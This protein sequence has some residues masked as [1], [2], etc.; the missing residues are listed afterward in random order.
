MV[1]V[2]ENFEKLT[3]EENG[4]EVVV[5][6]VSDFIYRFEFSNKHSIEVG[7][8]TK[9]EHLGLVYTAPLYEKEWREGTLL[10]QIDAFLEQRLQDE[11]TIELNYVINYYEDLAF[12]KPLKPAKEMIDHDAMTSFLRNV[13]L[14]QEYMQTNDQNGIKE[15][16]EEEKNR[17]VKGLF[18]KI[19]AKNGRVI[20][21]YI[22]TSCMDNTTLDYMGY[23]KGIGCYR[24]LGVD[25]AYVRNPEIIHLMD[26]DTI[27]SSKKT[28]SELIT[29]Y[30]EN[31]DVP[32]YLAKL[33]YQIQN[34]K[35]VRSA[36][37]DYIRRTD[38]YNISSTAGSPQISFRPAVAED[39]HAIIRISGMGL[40]DLPKEIRG[41]SYYED[42][43]TGRHL[44]IIGLNTS[45]NEF[46]EVAPVTGY[47]TMDRLTGFVDGS[48][49]SGYSLQ[50][51]F[52]D[53][54]K[55]VNEMMQLATKL[56][57]ID[58][59]RLQQEFDRVYVQVEKQTKIRARFI[60][61]QAK[62]FFNALDTG[63]I[64]LED[65]EL[66]VEQAAKV[67]KALLNYI[68]TNKEGLASLTKEDLE[69]AK[70]LLGLLNSRPS[71]D[72]TPLQ[73]G[74][75]EW[76]GEV[77]TI[78]ELQKEGD[79]V[80]EDGALKDVRS[81]DSRNSIYYGIEIGSFTY[82]D[83]YKRFLLHKDAQMWLTKGGYTQDQ[84]QKTIVE[85]KMHKIKPGIV[86]RSA[87]LKA[88]QN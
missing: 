36:S 11:E 57:G 9:P 86:E 61:Q 15:I 20:V 35:E 62:K 65:G 22:D 83:I 47:L 70:Y 48:G 50:S 87:W 40:I 73:L 13:V 81:P 76:L 23:G 67:D 14:I 34:L 39:L 38:G 21:S 31:P 51:G 12:Y 68:E 75:R 28:C 84:V 79:I 18:E 69:Y 59:A 63:N 4:H 72:V 25:Y 26:V 10:K 17:E 6:E 71:G 54:I 42:T 30:E 16:L 3:D 32:Y 1:L 5:T 29:Y 41:S 64:T 43:A 60:R 85:D 37:S 77:K 56:P 49:R 55:R 52:T 33:G 45:A 82:G 24:T 44:S 88:V 53:Y 58:Y 80:Y 74:L 8:P 27:P 46:E 66:I 7:I 78:E 19:I 2:K